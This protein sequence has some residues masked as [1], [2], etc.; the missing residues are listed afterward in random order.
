MTFT[1]QGESFREAYFSA[2]LS[3]SVIDIACEV[4][5]EIWHIGNSDLFLLLYSNCCTIGAAW[6]RIEKFLWAI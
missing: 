6:T 1:W 2:M 3:I 5:N 4:Q